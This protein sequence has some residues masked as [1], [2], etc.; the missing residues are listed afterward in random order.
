M[1]TYLAETAEKRRPKLGWQN[2]IHQRTLPFSQGFREGIEADFFDQLAGLHLMAAADSPDLLVGEIDL[3]FL[4][5]YFNPPP[6]Y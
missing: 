5:K 1:L 3:S 4:H 2:L 6:R